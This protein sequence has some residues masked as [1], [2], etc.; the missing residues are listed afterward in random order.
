MQVEEY[1]Y[2]GLYIS[3][4]GSDTGDL[5]RQ[6]CYIYSKGN[7]LVRKFAKFSDKLNVSSLRPIVTTCILHIYGVIILTPS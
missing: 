7:M 2:L 5:Q 1:K 3:S 6:I 4:H